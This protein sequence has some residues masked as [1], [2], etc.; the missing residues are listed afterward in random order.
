MIPATIRAWL[1]QQPKPTALRVTLD[2]EAR[3]INVGTQTWA[4]IASTVCALEP[5]LIEALDERGGVL[6]AT[7]GETDDTA[8]EAPTHTPAGPPAMVDTATMQL[9]A[10]LLADAYKHSTE[11]AFERLAN[12][13]DVVS[14][15]TE[16]LERSLAASERMRLREA[17]NFS[18]EGGGEQSELGSVLQQLFAG[19]ADLV[20]GTTDKTTNGKGH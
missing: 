14:R 15:R 17:A 5:Q 11:V 19:G 18:T 20:K 10:R 1:I 16:N 7:R 8:P 9:V 12:L 3:I 6:R 2:G 13:F 4:R